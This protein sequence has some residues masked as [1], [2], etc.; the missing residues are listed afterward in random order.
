[1][2]FLH[3]TVIEVAPASDRREMQSYFRS[4]ALKEMN[5]K[6]IVMSPTPQAHSLQPLF[7]APTQNG[8][9]KLASQAMVAAG[10]AAIYS[11]EG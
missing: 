5:R 2:P 4:Y 1:M 11:C 6:K 7:S 8:W 3:P 10:E 9:S